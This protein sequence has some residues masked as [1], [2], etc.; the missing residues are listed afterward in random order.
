MLVSIGE[1]AAILGVCRK[2]LRRWDAANKL[3]AFRTEGRHRRYDRKAL[4]GYRETGKY[5]PA[6]DVAT[7]CAAIYCRVSSHKQKEDLQRQRDV[8]EA[9]AIADGFRPR[10]YMDIGSGLN[11][12]RKGLLKFIRDAARRKFDAA[13]ITY[14]DRLARFGTR[15]L[16]EMLAIAG[17]PLTAIHSA[18]EKAPQETLME[19]MV[20]ILYSFS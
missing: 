2:T 5:E 12:N 6:A 4:L 18:D 11:D 19:D 3:E 15:P 14:M 1:A 9:R 17:I 20:A 7:G 13:Y 8:L 10:A 16:R